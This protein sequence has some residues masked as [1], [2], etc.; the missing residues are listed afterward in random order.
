[1]PVPRQQKHDAPHLQ[2]RDSQPGSSH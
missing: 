1:L 2:A